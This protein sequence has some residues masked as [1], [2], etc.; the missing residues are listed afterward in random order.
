MF[1][2]N[3]VY[4]LRLIKFDTLQVKLYNIVMICSLMPEQII[5][6]IIEGK[7]TN[8]VLQPH[9]TLAVKD[10]PR[11]VSVICSNSEHY[12]LHSFF[13]DQFFRMAPTEDCGCMAYDLMKV[14]G[15]MLPFRGG[16][17]HHILHTPRAVFLRDERV[18]VHEWC[19]H[20]PQYMD[21]LTSMLFE[22]K[23]MFENEKNLVSNIAE[24]IGF[25]YRS[26]R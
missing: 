8:N 13:V 5:N 23:E 24:K 21:S 26:P 11:E 17:E 4:I 12:F 14:P 25:L 10:I 1:V 7:I 20:N 19:T 18:F 3:R 16:G 15:L 9:Y 6:A 22:T 2:N